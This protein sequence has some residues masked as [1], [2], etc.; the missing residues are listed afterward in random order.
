[1]DLTT[2]STPIGY[3]LWLFGFTGSHR[4]YYG[5]PWTG[6]LWFLTGGLFFV[7][8]IVD[9]FLVPTM[10]READLR[11]KPGPYNYNISWILV[12]FVG[13][14]GIH[15]FYMKKWITGLLWLF[16]GGLFLMGWLYDLWTINQQVSDL[17]ALPQ[18]P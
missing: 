18:A 1:M 8:W 6:T 4:F 13:Y 7:G 17:N 11:F 12:T 9:F 2:H 14:L 10:E 5:K 15:R 3:V 16:T